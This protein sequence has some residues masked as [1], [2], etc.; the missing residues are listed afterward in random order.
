MPFIPTEKSMDEIL[1]GTFV[2]YLNVWAT[3]HDE[4]DLLVPT[5]LRDAIMKKVTNLGSLKDLIDKYKLSGLAMSF[6]VEFD[7]WGS[8]TADKSV[9]IYT[10]PN[11]HIEQAT[12]DA[13][14]EYA[15]KDLRP[16]VTVAQKGKVITRPLTG[17]SQE[18][19][20]ALSKLPSGD[21]TILIQTD[22]EEFF[23]Y[24]RKVQYPE[25]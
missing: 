11:H 7:D 1:C 14:K 19:L 10:Y 17:I 4:G 12:F 25:E 2:D 6:D 22:T 15:A 24:E 21:D 8:W 20:D 3:V 23:E 5:E 13:W 18:W 9:D 16:N